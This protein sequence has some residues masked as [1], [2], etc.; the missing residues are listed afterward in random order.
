MGRLVIFTNCVITFNKWIPLKLGVI[1]L[2]ICFE[3][4][5]L[6]F[7][8]LSF[9]SWLVVCQYTFTPLPWNTSH[10]KIPILYLTWCKYLHA[11]ANWWFFSHHFALAN[12][13]Y[14]HRLNDEFE[15]GF[16]LFY[17]PARLAPNP[18]LTK[19]EYL[20]ANANWLFF[21]HHFA[22]A[23]DKYPHRLINDRWSWRR[24]IHA[25]HPQ[26][27]VIPEETKNSLEHHMFLLRRVVM[28]AS[29]TRFLSSSN[30]SI[31]RL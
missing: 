1:R 9:Y 20:P 29:I 30:P 24:E 28:G 3:A 23:N 4:F 27:L 12:D 8:D 16:P 17:K 18:Y 13:K 2:S 14:P 10:S 6:L 31:D 21:S 11:N 22:L 19:C 5:T 7:K 26:D 15:D 25:G